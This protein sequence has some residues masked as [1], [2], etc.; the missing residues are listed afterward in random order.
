MQYCTCTSAVYLGVL[1]VVRILAPCCWPHSMHAS[2]LVPAA[3][4][5]SAASAGDALVTGHDTLLLARMPQ[6]HVP[7]AVGAALVHV[8]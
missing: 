2:V 7:V 4:A 1:S 6:V 3:S 8:A 5:A